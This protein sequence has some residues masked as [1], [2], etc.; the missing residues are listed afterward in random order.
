MRVVVVARNASKLEAAA[1]EMRVE[2]ADVANELTAGRL[3]QDLRPDLVML[4]AGGI[5]SAEAAPPAQL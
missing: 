2:H 1:K 3:L 4:C 5:P